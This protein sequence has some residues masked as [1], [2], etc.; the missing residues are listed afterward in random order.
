MVDM[1]NWQEHY[2]KDMLSAEEAAK[3]VKSGDYVV[4][5]TGREATSV[6]K[7]IAARKDDLKGTRVLIPSPINDFGWYDTENKEMMEVFEII[8]GMPTGISQK[9]ID[10]RQCDMIPSGHIPLLELP[11]GPPNVLLTE[12]SPPNEQGFCSFGNSVWNKRNQIREAK[13]TIAEVNDKL[14]WPHGETII[15]CSEIDYF[16]EH[17]QTGRVPGKGTLAGRTVRETPEYVKAI[18]KNVRSLLR[19]GDCIQIGI[20]RTTEP[21]VRLGLL[22]GKNDLGYHSEATPP[23]II[24]AVKEGIITGKYK[25]PDYGQWK[26]VCTSLGGGTREEMEWADNNPLF[27]LVNLAYL[28]DVRVIAAH[29]NVV[30]INNCLA[31]DLRGQITAESLGPKLMSGAGGQIPFVMAAFLSKGG[32]AI[33]VLPSTAQNGT[34]SRI[35]PFFPEG[36]V[37]TIQMHCADYVVTEYGIAHMRGKTSRQRAEELISIAHPDFRDELRKQAEKLLWP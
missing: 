7:A 21:M 28:E 4:F 22:E 37:V 8:V 32:R 26:C 23:G 10:E 5:T 35:V 9:M 25:P 33:T 29:D 2:Q 1:L 34:V 14:V 27:E 36:T 12:V 13:L 31:V 30:A 3:L 11:Y 24:T 18:M 6:G 15:H 20:G 19:D 17:E 16:V